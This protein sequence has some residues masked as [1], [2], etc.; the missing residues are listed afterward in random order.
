MKDNKPMAGI[1]N[2]SGRAVPF[3]AMEGFQNVREVADF[4]KLYGE[5]LPVNLTKAANEAEES[6]SLDDVKFLAPIPNMARNVICLGKNYVDHVLEVKGKIPDAPGIP[7]VPIYFSKFANPATAHGDT[8]ILDTDVTTQLDYEAELA[9]VIGKT[10]K[11]VSKEDAF[12]Y[13]FGYTVL[14]DLSARD[15]QNS[16]V[17]WF[18]GKNLDGFCPIGPVIVHKDEIRNPMNL[19][20]SSR[21]NGEQRQCSNT[22]NMIFN[23]PFIIEDLSKTMTLYPGDIISTG[24]PEGVGMG[25]TPPKYLYKGDVVEC[26]IEGIGVLMNRIG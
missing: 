18:K 16:H 5:K 6:Y 2:D 24:T 20:I 23:I 12:D 7:K 21:V 13:I 22:T 4:I 25:F 10:C 19:K 8:V 11:K 14:N 9:I 26:E 17:Q 3:S 1:V 15:I